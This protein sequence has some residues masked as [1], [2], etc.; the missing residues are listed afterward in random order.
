MEE[1]DKEREDSH[2]G[3]RRE[4]ADHRV[5]DATVSAELRGALAALAAKVNAQKWML[6]TVITLGLFNVAAAIVVLARAGR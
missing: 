3:I 6:L 5:E 1:A 4:L 2:A